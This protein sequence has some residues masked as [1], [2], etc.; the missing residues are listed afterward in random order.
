VFLNFGGGV[1][2]H[3]IGLAGGH[4]RRGRHIGLAGGHDRRDRHIGLAGG[5][6]VLEVRGIDHASVNL[7]L[8]ESIINL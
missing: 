7:E 6:D 5:H 8:C 3:H 1:V 2:V 4:D